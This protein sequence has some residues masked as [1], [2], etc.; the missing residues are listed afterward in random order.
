MT[1][2]LFKDPE[3]LGRIERG[4]VMGWTGTLEDLT[5]MAVPLSSST[6][7]YLSGQLILLTAD[8]ERTEL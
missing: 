4:I 7:D 8:T 3:R 1:K 2:P 5:G 6:S